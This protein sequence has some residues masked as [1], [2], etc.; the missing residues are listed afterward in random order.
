MAKVITVAELPEDI[1]RQIRK[2]GPTQRRRFMRKVVGAVMQ[3]QVVV[4]FERS[5]YEKENDWKS[6]SHET[7]LG[8]RFAKSYR[9]RPSGDAVALDSMRLF[10]E[11]YFAASYRVLDADANS[12]TVGPRVVAKG[13]KAVKIAERAETTKNYSRGGPGWGNNI[14]GFTPETIRALNT[15]FQWYLDRVANDLPVPY[16]PKSRV[17]KRAKGV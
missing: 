5:G 12:V 16:L 1:R 10:D 3:G 15:E 6:P 11:G 13:G 4:R 17:G 7:Q 14:V 9:V 2:F 8:G